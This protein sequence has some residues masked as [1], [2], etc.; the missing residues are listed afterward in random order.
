[1]FVYNIPILTD[2]NKVTIFVK[3]II[4]IIIILVIT[5]NTSYTI[6]FK[7]WKHKLD[8]GTGTLTK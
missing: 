6:L 4:N 8:F 7:G 5:P 1:M 3:Y 2:M